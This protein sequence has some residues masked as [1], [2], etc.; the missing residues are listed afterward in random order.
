MEERAIIRHSH[1]IANARKVSMASVATSD[2]QE[3]TVKDGFG[4]VIM[5]LGTASYP[6]GLTPDQARMFAKQLKEC[7]DRVESNPASPA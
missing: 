6:A 1:G 5:S 2:I 3:V 7:A 4:E